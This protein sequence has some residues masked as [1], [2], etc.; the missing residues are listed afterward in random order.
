VPDAPVSL[1][2]DPSTTIDTVIR[3]TWSDGASDGGSPVID[4]TVYYDQGSDSFVLLENS[5][6]TQYY[7]TTVTLS[8]GTTYKFKV[9]ARNSVG[10]SLESG[11]VVILAAK[12]PDAPLNLLNVPAITTAYQIGLEWTEGVYNGGSPV[13]D[14]ELSYT[15]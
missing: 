3:F 12:T 15:E 1:T 6:T 8:P 11:E 7:Q 9:T 10:S 2:N 4:Y 5:V 14:Y 13:I